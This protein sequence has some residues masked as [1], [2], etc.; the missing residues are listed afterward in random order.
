MKFK[1]IFVFLFGF[2]K[3]F[4]YSTFTYKYYYCL[5]NEHILYKSNIVYAVKHNRVTLIIKLIV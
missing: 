4:L 5:L 1:K 2:K 3:L